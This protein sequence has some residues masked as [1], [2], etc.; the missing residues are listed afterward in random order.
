MW[1]AISLWGALVSGQV[2][3]VPL[4]AG[5]VTLAPA[6]APAPTEAQPTLWVVRNDD[7]PDS[8]PR[9]GTAGRGHSLVRATPADLGQVLAAPLAPALKLSPSLRRQ[10]VGNLLL[11]VTPDREPLSVLAALR[12]ELG[13]S[14]QLKVVRL[15]SRA[16]LRLTGYPSDRASLLRLAAM[17]GLLWIQPETLPRTAN[18]ESVGPIQANA[19]SGGTPPTATP[20]WDQG[21]LGSGQIIGMADSGLDRNEAWFTQLDRGLGVNIRLTDAIPTQPP[22]PGPLFPDRKVIGYWVMPGATAYDNDAACGF[23]PNGFHGTHVVGTAVGDAGLASTPTQPNHDP[24]DGMA[25]QAQVLF[26]DLGDDVAGCL[27]GAGGGPMWTQ[28][29]AAGAYIHSNSYGSSYIGDY[30]LQDFAVD[31]F[32]WRHPDMLLVFAAGNAGGG[33]GNP[34][35]FHFGHAK[36]GLTVGALARGNSPITWSLS[37]RG[38]AS[39]GRLKPDI[40]APGV[41]IR[42]AAGD[43][44]NTGFES[45]EIREFTGTS[46]AAPAVAGAAAMARQYFAEGFYPTGS[47][48]ADD[49]VLPSGMLLKALLLNGT[50]TDTDTPSLASGWGRVWLD[51]NLYFAGDARQVR[52]FDVPGAA[53]LATG[54]TFQVPVTVAAGAALRAT[55]VWYDPPPSFVAA[56]ALVNNLDLRVDG[57]AGT[58]LGNVFAGGESAA[59]G[60]ADVLNPVEQVLLVSPAAGDYQIT[61]TGTAVPGDLDPESRRQGF[62]LAVSSAQCDSAV[63]DAP[64]FSLSTDAAGVTV[65]VAAVAGAATYQVYRQPGACGAA[66][67]RLVGSSAASTVIDATAQGG[68]TYAYRVRAADGCGEGP[69]SACQSIVS[70]GACSLSPHSI[71]SPPRLTANRSFC[72]SRLEWEPAAATCPGASLRYE[73]HRAT[74]PFFLPEQATRVAEVDTPR[75]DDYAAAP[76]VTHYYRVVAV[77]SLGNRSAPSLPVAYSAVSEAQESGDYLDDVDTLALATAEAPWQVSS[78][79]ASGGGLSY[80]SAQPGLNYPPARCAAI[81]TPAIELQSGARLSFAARYDLEPSYDGVVLE[82][83]VAGGAWQDLPPAE[84]YPG[85]FELTGSTPGN[86]CGFAASQGAFSGSS[87]GSFSNYSADLSAYAGREVRLRWRLSTDPLMEAEGFYLDSVR[88]D[89]ASR[90]MECTADELILADGFD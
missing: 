21:L 22:L 46:M 40:T 6:S 79:Q 66:A 11:A 44:Q 45:G 36:H 86:A 25:P 64:D 80:A 71:P 74:D 84:G 3:E 68:L 87:G 55:L 48:V 35:V 38:P 10:P 56:E 83:S 70:A 16:H 43:N 62:A 63:V 61:V 33:P 9:L 60:T 77:D 42:S 26:Q 54:E 34:Q 53:G 32:L 82:I 2:P 65:E 41:N 75:F 72:A 5:T 1:E 76:G 23:A 50:R 89:A 18:S 78:I 20:I 39:D 88:V 37:S 52:V 81:T 17:P 27:T 8:I 47:R 69:V 7:M 57:P 24:G 59:G 85:S 19:S 12:R 4:N 49:E 58:F 31:D 14:L 13:S 67:E 29:R 30:N 28:A 73:V 90:P 15:S 51:S